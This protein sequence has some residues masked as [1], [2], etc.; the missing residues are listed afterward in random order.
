[1]KSVAIV[2]FGRFGK[3]LF[4]LLDG[5]FEIGVYDVCNIERSRRYAK[6]TL[7]QVISQCKNNL[8]CK[9][10]PLKLTSRKREN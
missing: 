5:D 1:M 7:L 4:R 9:Y 8:A 3:T 10:P 6:M 2:G